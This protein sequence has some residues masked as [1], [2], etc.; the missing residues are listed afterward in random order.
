MMAQFS[1]NSFPRIE[2]VDGCY[3]LITEYDAGFVTELKA[4]IPAS[5]RRYD[6][7]SRRWKVSAQYGRV[8]ADLIPRYFGVTAQLPSS[9]PNTERIISGILRVFYIGACKER[10]DGESSASGW[11]ESGGWEIIFPEAVLRKWFDEGPE[12]PKG[13]YFSI[14]GLKPGATDDEIRTGYRRMAKLWHPDLNKEY[15]A[16]AV[17]RRIQ[18][19]YD[20]LKTPKMRA[21]YEA[22]LKLEATLGSERS[23]ATR[24]FAGDHSYGYRTPLLNGLIL[25][26]YEVILG[27]KIVREIKQWLDVTCDGKTL[28]SSWVMGEDAPRLNWV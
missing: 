10:S 21:R 3:E 26:E 1:Q 16:A 11:S 18:T 7:T 13:N 5:H 9:P 8:A 24:S 23:E 17:F 2:L 4:T 25:A 14:L 20:V 27:R 28:V 19:A 15:N 22:G 6:P 12:Q